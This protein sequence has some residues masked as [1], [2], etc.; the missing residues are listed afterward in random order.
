[1]EG[2]VQIVEEI[3]EERIQDNL[4]IARVDEEKYLNELVAYQLHFEGYKYD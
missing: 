3:I 1:V 2:M 4:E